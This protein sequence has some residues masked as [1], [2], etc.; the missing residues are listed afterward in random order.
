MTEPL[1]SGEQELVKKEEF[2]KI[3]GEL[4]ATKK[5]LEDALKQI[6][7]SKD[8]FLRTAAD[9]ENAKKRLVREKEDFVRYANENLMRGILPV[10]DNLERA[11]S[12]A[13]TAKDETVSSFRNGVSLIKKQLSDLLMA[14]GLVRL[15]TVGKKF[16][17]HLQ[18]AIGHA[19]TADVPE[20]TV[21]EEL[22]AGYLLEGRL[23]RP[24][25]VRISQPK[26]QA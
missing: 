19:E 11:L 6:A 14:Q 2:E 12:H 17:P 22:E 9:F 8:K 21:M 25:K 23:I 7:E 26:A 13:E 15:D 3:S 5:Q 18:E 1:E 20:D 24:A 16:D 10:L 4:E